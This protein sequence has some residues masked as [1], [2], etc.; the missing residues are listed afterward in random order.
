MLRNLGTAPNTAGPYRSG[1]YVLLYEGSGSFTY[2]NDAVKNTGMSSPGRD[3]LDVTSSSAGISIFL[4]A[5]D[6]SNTGNY[7]RNIRLVYAPTATSSVI[8]PNETAA[9]A[10]AAG[11]LS[12]A[13]NPDFINRISSFKTLRFMEWTNVITNPQ[14]NWTDRAKPNWVFWDEGVPDNRRASRSRECWG[15]H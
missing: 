6:P 1:R 2:F 11:D 12:Q 10:A 15:T 13:F 8:D 3:V 4:T 7:V 5:T 14:V 9:T